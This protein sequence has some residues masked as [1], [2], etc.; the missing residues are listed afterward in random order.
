MTYSAK[1]NLHLQ[2][3]L[4]QEEQETQIFVRPETFRT[5]FLCLFRGLLRGLAAASWPGWAQMAAASAARAAI[6]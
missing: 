5:M 4:L 2:L 6:N 1:Q 3:A